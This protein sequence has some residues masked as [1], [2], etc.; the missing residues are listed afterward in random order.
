MSVEDKQDFKLETTLKVP[1]LKEVVKLSE[2]FELVVYLSEEA[3]KEISSRLYEA[4]IY[5]K[6]AK[7]ILNEPFIFLTEDLTKGKVIKTEKAKLRV[8]KD[9]IVYDF[10]EEHEEWKIK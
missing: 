7:K 2:Q 1:Y 9:K 4:V 3:G 6:K 5:D 10:E 8:E